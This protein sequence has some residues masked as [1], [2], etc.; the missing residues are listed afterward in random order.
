[1]W[2]EI[3]KPSEVYSESEKIIQLMSTLM[4]FRVENVENLMNWLSETNFIRSGGHLMIFCD[5]LL[6]CSEYNI[7]NI[8]NYVKIIVQVNKSFNVQFQNVNLKEYL[9][10]FCSNPVHLTNAQCLF[11]LECLQAGIFNTEECLLHFHY[12][13]DIDYKIPNTWLP[14]VVWFGPI[15]EQHDHA[16][17]RDCIRQY[18]TF[19]KRLYTEKTLENKAN[20]FEDLQ[21]NKWN[22]VTDPNLIGTSPCTLYNVIKN[23][24]LSSLHSFYQNKKVK[25]NSRIDPSIVELNA[26][27]DYSPTLIEVAAFF[28]STKC[29]QFL[30][31]KLSKLDVC[32]KRGFNVIHYAAAGGN[33]EMVDR[34][35]AMG[36]SFE[37]V[38]QF[39]AYCHRYELVEQLYLQYPDF[40]DHPIKNYGSVMHFC[41]MSNNIRTLLFCI[42]NHVDINARNDICFFW[43]LKFGFYFSWNL[44]IDVFIK[45]HF[46]AQFCI[47]IK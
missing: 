31:S 19:F 1:M 33:M 40:I 4:C 45:L 22:Y 34:L 43:F 39:A 6:N 16:L 37:G 29:F 9:L 23:D 18:V 11:L 12:F 15:I 36:F 24:D 8:D 38:F 10:S 14:F 7:E 13:F 32:D 26:F 35:L 30:L 25:V 20:Q 21:K 47:V 41:A 5:I 42:Q 2:R 3:S 17:F 28:N 27:M 46:I 44:N